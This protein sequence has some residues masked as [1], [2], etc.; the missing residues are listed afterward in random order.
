MGIRALAE[1]AISLAQTSIQWMPAEPEAHVVNLE[2]VLA[3]IL[4]RAVA[5]RK[6]YGNPFAMVWV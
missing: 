5:I 3:E 1:D 2:L 4:L 6:S